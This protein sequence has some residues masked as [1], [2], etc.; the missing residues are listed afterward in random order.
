[1]SNNCNKKE[2]DEVWYF[3]YGSN[4][5]IPQ[6]LARVGE[7]KTSKKALLRGW[8]LKFNH[9]S[10]R[11]C[12]GTANIVKTKNPNDVVHGVIYLLNRQKLKVLSKYEGKSA[13]LQKITVESEEKGIEAKTYIFNQTKPNLKPAP[14][15]IQTIVDGLIQHGYGEEA[16]NTIPIPKK[17]GD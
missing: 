4:L 7:W 12:A 13:R 1:M 3:A 2:C 6:M 10:K 15:Y 5:Y 17:R 14:A 9:Y 11:W 16:I 8:R